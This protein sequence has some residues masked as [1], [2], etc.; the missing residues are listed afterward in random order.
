[1]IRTSRAQKQGQVTVFIIIGLVLLLTIGIII[2]F[3]T[4]KEPETKVSLDLQPV[5]T[6]V[7]ECLQQVSAPAVLLLAAQG[8]YIYLPEH[9]ALVGEVKVGYG[10]DNGKKQLLDIESMQA[11][12]NKYIGE[13]L[14]ACIN[15]FTSLPGKNIEAGAMKVKTAIAKNNVAVVIDY[16]VTVVVGDPSNQQTKET[17]DTFSTTVNLRLGYV[18]EMAGNVLN[19]QAA[20]KEYL[21]LTYLQS[22]DVPIK[23]ITI[24]KET[25][26][27]SFEDNDLIFQTAAKF[28]VNTAPVLQLDTVYTLK[29]EQLFT[30]E[31]PYQSDDPVAFSDDSIFFTIEHDGTNNGNAIISFIPHITGEFPVKIKVVDSI[32]QTTEQEILLKVIT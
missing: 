27:F 26:L 5:K 2:F 29:D 3:T 15:G 14:Q 8:G 16:P 1:M 20:D 6:F 12:L 10:Y 24:D 32:G 18:Y 22:F 13:Q 17:I 21:D 19:K 11:Q 4:S 9:T 23:V 25:L 7:D 31:I 28:P 30:L